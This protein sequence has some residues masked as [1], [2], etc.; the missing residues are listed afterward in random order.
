[1]LAIPSNKL[2]NAHAAAP[3]L[4]VT[5]VE[6]ARRELECTVGF[7]QEEIIVFGLT[8]RKV[9]SILIK[10]QSGIPKESLPLF[11]KV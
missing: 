9:C 4:E 3:F 6:F 5:H 8:V 2:Q 11:F 1:M 7:D 10:V